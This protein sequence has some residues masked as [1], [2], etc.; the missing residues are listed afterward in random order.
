MNKTEMRVRLD[1]RAGKIKS[2]QQE[3]TALQ[4][5]VKEVKIGNIEIPPFD[6]KNIITGE[7]MN[8]TL[9]LAHY[10]GVETGIL[11]CGEVLSSPIDLPTEGE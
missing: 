8:L 7:K 1:E 3:L 6:D 11:L 5:K 2:L 10:M 9:E 4:E